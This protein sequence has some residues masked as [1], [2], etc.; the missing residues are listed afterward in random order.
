MV[1]NGNFDA[2]N[3][4]IDPDFLYFSWLLDLIKGNYYEKLMSTL[5]KTD[6]DPDPESLDNNRA[7]DG[8]RLR[9]RWNFETR[10]R[11]P[12]KHGPCTF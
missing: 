9:D 10:G 11:Y 6:F 7:C 3:R 5:Y 2:P 1:N 4:L 8:L 12:I